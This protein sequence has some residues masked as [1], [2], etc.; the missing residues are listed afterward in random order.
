MSDI[1]TYSYKDSLI[2]LSSFTLLNDAIYK[3][4]TNI[5]NKIEVKKSP[6]NKQ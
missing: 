6:V 4:R 5:I 2:L 1:F 3:T